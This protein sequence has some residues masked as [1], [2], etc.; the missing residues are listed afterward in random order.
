LPTPQISAIKT[1]SMTSGTPP[2]SECAS[3][4]LTRKPYRDA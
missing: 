2:N 1:N 4:V 3:A